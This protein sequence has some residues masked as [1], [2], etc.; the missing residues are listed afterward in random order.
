MKMPPIH[1]KLYID[2]TDPTANMA[3]KTVNV[4]G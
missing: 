4:A 2:A 3:A 1:I